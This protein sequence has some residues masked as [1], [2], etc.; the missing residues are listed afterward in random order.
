METR[1]EGLGGAVP[2][3]DDAVHDVRIPTATPRITAT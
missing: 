1:V 3:T 2:G